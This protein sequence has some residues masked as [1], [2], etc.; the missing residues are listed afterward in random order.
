MINAETVGDLAR[1][2]VRFAVFAEGLVGENYE[3]RTITK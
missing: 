1:L 2:T 3:C